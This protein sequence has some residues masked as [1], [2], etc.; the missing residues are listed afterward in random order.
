MEPI[1][2]KE[3]RNIHHMK[4]QELAE[5]LNVSQQ[6]ISRYENGKHY[7]DLPALIV[8]ADFFDVPI[9]Y[10]VGRTWPKGP[11]SELYVDQ[12]LA[13]EPQ[14]QDAPLRDGKAGAEA[15]IKAEM[16]HIVSAS[17]ACEALSQEMLDLSRLSPKRAAQMRDIYNT[18]LAA[19]GD[20]DK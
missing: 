8:I 9:D 3:L 10:L 19:E 5:A 7:P 11:V 12:A 6:S 13:Y 14:D 2:L 1:K 17:K 18:M 4:Q 20:K 15:L 16:L